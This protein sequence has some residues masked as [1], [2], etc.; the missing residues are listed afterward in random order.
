MNRLDFADT[1]IARHTIEA[2]A[3][4][5]AEKGR[6]R[7]TQAVRTLYGLLADAMSGVTR[8]MNRLGRGL[9]AA[10][11]L[12][13]A[14]PPERWKDLSAQD[15]LLD[16]WNLIAIEET[17]IEAKQSRMPGSRSAEAKRL[18]SEVARSIR[19]LKAQVRSAR[20]WII[21]HWPDAWT[22][23]EETEFSR[24]L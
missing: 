16:L 4:T 24:W 7:D 10:S 18:R 14:F 8:L 21:K 22:E 12:G 19:T 11:G 5:L 9:R 3:Q 15:I 1:Q 2:V 17:A 23:I 6:E 20:A 13:A